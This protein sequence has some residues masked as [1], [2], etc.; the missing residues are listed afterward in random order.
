MGHMPKQKNTA[1]K[2]EPKKIS[3]KSKAIKPPSSSKIAAKTNKKTAPAIGGIKE[4]KKHRFR[5]GTVALREI[6]RYQKSTALLLPRAPFQRLVRNICS[7][8]DSDLRFQAQGLLA[9]QEAAE[10]YLVGIFEDSNLCCLHAKRVTV[11]KKDME[12]ARRIRGD[13]NHDFVNRGPGPQGEI[14]FPLPY[15]KPKKGE[16][17]LKS[18]IDRL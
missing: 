5:P 9:L 3:S 17:E 18:Q 2:I 4:A 14:V 7:N 1:A 8:I 12:L 13:A 16:A 10:A 15:S 6:K 11:M